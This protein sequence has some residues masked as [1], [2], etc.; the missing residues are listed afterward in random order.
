MGKAIFKKEILL[1]KR[2]N[3]NEHIEEKDFKIN[4]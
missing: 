4:L 1:R 2:L 3:D